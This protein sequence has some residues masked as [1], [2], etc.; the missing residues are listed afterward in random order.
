MDIDATLLSR[1][2]FGF[3]VT[4]HI[5]FPSFTIGLAAW[6]ATIEGMR[7]ATGEQLYRRLF[8]FWLK[9]F[10]LSF[11]MGVV[12]GI[13][14]AF[15]FGSN[16]SVLS[17]RTGP[18]QG[19]LLGYEAFTAFLLEATF[20]GVVM[21]GRDRAPPWF[22]FFS[23]CMVSLGTMFSSFWI[24]CN[25]SWMQVPLGHAMV[26]DRFVPTDWAAIALGP[27]VRVRWP[28]MLL[29]AFCTTAL[30]V[31]STGAFYLLRGEWRQEGR[32]MLH[33]G[34]GLLAVLVP[35]QMMFGHWTGDYVHKHQPAKFAA[36]EAR[37]QTEQPASEVLIAWP[38]ETAQTNRFA[39]SIPSL[40]SY[41][42]TGTWNSREVGLETF[43]PEDRPPVAIT[44]FTFRIMVGLGL[45]MLAIAWLGVVISMLGRLDSSRLF[46]RL[47]FISF[48]AGFVAV[49]AGWFTA[50]IGR[51][52]WVVYGL[53]RTREA[54]TPSL[55]T[56]DVAVSLFLYVLV[57]GVVYAFGVWYLYRLIGGGFRKV[58]ADR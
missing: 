31:A 4:F 51:Q 37:W 20:F 45:I 44:F 35:A 40:G 56:A 46:L 55:S 30:C 9:V 13:V 50:E 54:V 15:Q 12:S 57:Y 25:N 16:W 17:L 6:L 33:W 24:L 18:I 42:A 22:Y 34:L 38:D 28:H 58:E 3:V 23:C 1:I 11:G 48:P 29:G 49:I 26:G 41:I 8:D 32:A 53:L 14:M 43:R 52:P 19:P 36:I 21:F 39:I 10:A 7:L 27:I 47:T 2:Q 5:I